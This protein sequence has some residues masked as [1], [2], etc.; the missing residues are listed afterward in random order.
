MF[1]C[2]I[3]NLVIE[4]HNR[5]EYSYLRCKNYV[6]DSALPSDVVI[7]LTDDDVMREKTE[8]ITNPQIL[9]FS[10]IYRK[11]CHSLPYYDAFLIHGAAIAHGGVGYIF[12]A[13][14]GTGKTTH[15]EYWRKLFSDGV[16]VING[17]KPIIRKKDG[18]LTVFGTPWCGK[19][20][21]NEN[22]SAPVKNLCFIHRSK[23]NRTEKI[24]TDEALLQIMPQLLLPDDEGELSRLFD[25]V[26]ELINESGRYNVFCNMSVDA[27]K[28]AHS[29]MTK[30]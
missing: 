9:E 29:E 12:C 5:H 19:E 2:R 20:G 6:C 11:L 30:G 8:E 13:N 10:A 14:S 26:D 25:L 22:T 16:T 3:A 28:V 15:I 18:V 7:T 1:K 27:A 24:S 17:D 23:D 21:Y 4:I